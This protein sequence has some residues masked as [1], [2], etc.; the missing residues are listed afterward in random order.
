MEIEVPTRARSS[1]SLLLDKIGSVLSGLSLVAAALGLIY[2]L[3]LA[4]GWYNQ[5][6]LGVMTSHSLTVGTT[7]P[8]TDEK[9]PG[10]LA[11]LQAGDQ[12]LALDKTSFENLAD[13]GPALDS[14]LAADTTGQLVTVRIFRPAQPNRL[15]INCPGF[16]SATAEGIICN[17]QL[18]LVHF[19]LADFAFQFGIGLLV[20]L[21]ILV[22]GATLWVLRRAQP[23]A[24]LVTALCAAGAMTIL[25]RFELLSTYRTALLFAAATCFLSGVLL[26][27]ALNFPYELVVARRLPVLRVL[28]LVIALSGFLWCVATYLQ[29]DVRA[30]DSMELIAVG[31]AA[32]G[33]ISFIG[34]LLLR[35]RRSTSPVL[36]DQAAIALVGG[37]ISATP[38]VL[39]L[40]TLFLDQFGVQHGIE[41]SGLTFSSIYVIPPTLIFPAA[42][43]YGLLQY[44]FLD[45]DRIISESLIYT[46]LGALLV[47]GYLLVTTAAFYLTNGIIRAQNPILVA[48]TLFL[49]AV[50]FTPARLRL[51]RMVDESFFKQRRAYQVRLERFS[52]ELTQAVDLTD[53]VSRLKREFDETLSPRYLFVF[54]LNTATNEYEAF[55]DAPGLSQ[56]DVRFGAESSL[57]RVMATQQPIIYIA[58]GQALLPELVSERARLAVLNT[59]IMA[60][61]QS[62]TR[63]NG[64]I[65]LGPRIDSSSANYHYEDLR[66]V[67]ALAEQAASAFERAQIL[68]EAQRNARELRVLAQVSA[69]LNI[70]MDFDTLL[71]F[72]YAQSDKVINA[73]NF[74][75][76]LR[77]E[78]SDDL[79]YTFYQ[80]EGER[81]SEREGYRWHMGRDL[82]SEV[83]RLGQP[84]KTDNYV[85]DTQ[86]RDPRINVEN[87]ALRAWMGVPLNAGVGG[88]LG[89][90]A[91]ATTEAAVTYSDDEVRIFSNIADLAATAIYKTRLFSQTEERARQLKVLN[92]I[93]SRLGS[94][95]ENLEALLQVI[96]E[97]AIEILRAEAGSLLLRDEESG[98]LIFRLAVG[99]S[100]QDLVGSRIPAGEGIA[101]TV[102]QSGKHMIVNDTQQDNRWYG[103]VAQDGSA[104]PRAFATRAILAVP[105]T[106][107]G[108]SIGVLE[109]INKRDG[110]P[111]VEED[112]N[113]LTAFAGQA[114]VAIENARLFQM[115]DLAL[116]TRVQQLDNMQRIDQE[117]NRTLDLQ[118]VVDLTIDNA[119]R[120]SQADAGALAL[121]H[122]DPPGFEI[123]GSIGYPEEVLKISAFYPITLGI[124][125][126]VY[127]TT[128]AALISTQEMIAD[129][130]YIELLPGAKAQ[131]AV[132]LI[133]GNIV[134][135]VLLV[136]TVR[137]DTF[138]MMTASFIQ[139]LAEHANTAITNS[140]L[141]ARLEEA[142][143]ARSKFV[144]FVAHELKNPMASIKGYSEVLLGG[145]TGALNEQQQNFIAVIRRN[146]VRMQQLV[147][148]LRDLTAQETGNLTLKLAPVSFTNVI[149]ETLRPQ[150]RAIDEKGQKVELNYP[151]NLPLVWADELRL[152]QVMTNFISNANKYTPTGGTIKIMAEHVQNIWDP[153]GAPEVV[154]CA[155]TDTGIGMSEEDQKKL[156][157]PYWR[158]SNPRA[159][160]QPG[161]G[162]GMTLTRGLIEAHGGRI[163]V[164]STLDV[165]STFNMTV[166]LAEVQ[167][168]TAR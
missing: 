142:N 149:L 99:G 40:L 110:T 148:D 109:V 104:L 54:L 59:P 146:V 90:M 114:A 86:R 53:T 136:E 18:R 20:A 143:Q 120:E 165:G 144:G 154:H 42:L 12:I 139:G 92:D 48:G 45:S 89:C 150:Q 111:F 28:P 39:W 16:E 7:Q 164:E 19:P 128:Q 49:V 157:T 77:D 60:R 101:G 44:R 80:E 34:S 119:M 71:E 145:M 152:I 132:P 94:E 97:S 126:K 168:P 113:L 158:S 107:R 38:L 135:A 112:V 52:R 9:W 27:L 131:L 162:L 11:G 106:A 155:V 102:A 72:V 17:Y 24:R 125:G 123:A 14:A 91:I 57:P 129:R 116:A 25:G 43:M 73:P 117:L 84:L 31:L 167:E 74:Y 21:V 51:T 46:V 66:F 147:D 8:L 124:L 78:Q 151:E 30:S 108:G 88:T 127:R 159:Q 163:W 5:P 13:P 122:V 68:V 37:I 70:A 121:I 61:M 6:F 62:G 87:T 2:C 1:L 103:E 118:R 138:N 76:A 64:F 22:M 141:F 137:P 160:E 15:Q 115:T 35:R 83:V 10:L 67:Q 65:A 153:N 33:A 134:S 50:A 100:G 58:S 36:R 47:V 3:I 4:L 133:T 29:N 32:L 130:D 166:P 23:N 161:T 98:D 156:F 26:E 55:N 95:F 93:S 79:I 56:T 41:L 82:M 69:A 85:Q 75:I 140:Q 63:L 81:L 105:L 96:T